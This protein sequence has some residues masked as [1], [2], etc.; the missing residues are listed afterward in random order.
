MYFHPFFKI[1]FLEYMEVY[2]EMKR[3]EHKNY[4]EN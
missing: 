1:S 4:D 3:K 2:N